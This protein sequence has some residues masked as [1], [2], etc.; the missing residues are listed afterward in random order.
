MVTRTDILEARALL[1]PYLRPSPMIRSNH[2][3]ARLGLEIFLKLESLRDTGSFKV[4]GALH[5]LLHLSCEERRRGVVAAS[6]G[7]HAQG[8]AWAA[9]QLRVPA[10]VFMPRLAPIAKLLATRAYGATVISQGDT[11]DDAAAQARRWIQERGGTLIPG[12]DDPR[13]IAGQG[14]VGLEILE[15]LPEVDS[16]I[17]PA[18]GGGLLADRLVTVRPEPTIADG[19]AVAAPGELP[20]ALIRR[21]VDGV[22]A[23]DEGSIETAVIA[24]LER[25]HLV[26]EGA[27][28]SPLALL[29]EGRVRPRGRRVVLVVSGG[30]LDLHWMDRIVQRG[31]LRLGRRMRL[32]VLLPDLPGSLARITGIIAELGA[33]IL[34]IHHDRL[35]S[36]LRVQVSRVEFDLEIRGHDHAAEIRKA[37]DQAGLEMPL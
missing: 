32:K 8:V 28:A 30:N 36:D 11:Y 33:N 17:V 19:I 37:L 7:N 26:V 18:G 31:T 14:C 15:Q 9:G 25:K 34:Q 3:S 24:F 4:R 13:V 22:E 35:G 6:A 5:R 23:V 1:N 29:M 20:L 16:V 27:G 12:F 2:L 21:H 10:T